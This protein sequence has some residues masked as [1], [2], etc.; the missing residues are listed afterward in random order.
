MFVHHP[1]YGTAWWQADQRLALHG[2]P[3]RRHGTKCRVLARYPACLLG[4]LRWPFL[5]MRLLWWSA[6][7]SASRRRVV[8]TDLDMRFLETVKLP[9]LEVW[10]HDLTCDPLPEAAFDLVHARL[11][12]VHL[13]DK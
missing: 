9:G 2:R 4:G 10:R 8:V 1:L 12:L 7:G 13:P 11:V 6:P 3:S 5:S